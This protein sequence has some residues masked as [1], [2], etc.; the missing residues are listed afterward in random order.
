MPKSVQR[1]IA[2]GIT[3]LSTPDLCAYLLVFKMLP[4]SQAQQNL[5]RFELQLTQ[6]Q[7]TIERIA[8]HVADCP[9]Y[10]N[11]RSAKKPMR[12]LMKRR[13]ASSSSEGG[14]PSEFIPKK[15]K[16]LAND[17]GL[18]DSGELLYIFLVKLELIVI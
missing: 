11:S 15:R 5:D 18:S 10:H 3:P 8:V 4:I 17:E 1:H 14:F 13:R 9:H 12:H 6:I 7:H 16:T 2:V